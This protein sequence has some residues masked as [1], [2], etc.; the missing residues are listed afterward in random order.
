MIA[1]YADVETVQQLRKTDH[2]KLK[3]DR[4]YVQSEF[5]RLLKERAD[6]SD[7]LLQ[8]FEELLGVINAKAEPI[9]QEPGSLS[10]IFRLLS[11][12][13]EEPKDRGDHDDFSDEEPFEDA[14]ENQS[15][16]C[17]SHTGN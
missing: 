10:Q 14:F 15:H 2:F 11:G 1:L 6:L 3:Y 9:S 17:L 7:A 4:N 12:V 8:A 16:C 13:Q 5:V